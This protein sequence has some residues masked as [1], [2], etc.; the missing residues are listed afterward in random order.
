MG[1][2]IK[3][4]K[5]VVAIGVLWGILVNIFY[6]LGMISWAI[7]LFYGTFCFMWISG[8]AIDNVVWLTSGLIYSFLIVYLYRTFYW[9]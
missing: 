5:W 1:E 7:R 9:A 8:S 3:V 6:I 4:V 2:F